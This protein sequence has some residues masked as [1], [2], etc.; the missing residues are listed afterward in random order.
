MDKRILCFD[1][2]VT[3]TLLL[4]SFVVTLIQETF[5]PGFCSNFA[6]HNTWD[7]GI[8]LHI[9]G[10]EGWQHLIGNVTM[11]ALLGP[12]TEQNFGSIPLAIMTVISA[13]VI[14]IVSVITRIPCYGLSSIVYMWIVLNTFQMNGKKGIPVTCLIV[15]ACYVL[16]EFVELF[17]HADNIGHQNHILGAICGL[18]FGIVAKVITST[19]RDKPETSCTNYT[20]IA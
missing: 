17:K 14:G 11:I 10:H 3:L 8:V 5:I 2:P 12:S 15:L 16:P 20:E 6:T 1:S 18:C 7:A 13:A 4:V 9:F 19:K